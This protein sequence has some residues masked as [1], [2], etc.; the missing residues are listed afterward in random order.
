M[1]STARRPDIDEMDG[2]VGKAIAELLSRAVYLVLRVL[3]VLL[4][5]VYLATKAADIVFDLA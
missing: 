5:A 4:V 2:V 3:G 1:T